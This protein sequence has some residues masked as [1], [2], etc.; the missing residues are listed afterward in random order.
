MNMPRP[1]SS[2]DWR[3]RLVQDLEPL[4]KSD[5]LTAE[6][7]RHQGVPFAL[8]AYPPTDERVL[9]R[10]L[11]LLRT[12]VE[13]ETVRKVTVFSMAD[14]VMDAIRAVYGD[15]GLA[16]LAEMERSYAHLKTKERLDLLRG[17][18]ES[19][20]S[21]HYPVPAV[22]KKQMTTLDP[23]ASV[24]FITRIGRLYPFFRASALLE[25][26]MYEVQVPTILF[27]PGTRGAGR[28]TLRFMD[29]LEAVHSYRHRIF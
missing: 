8:F 1:W 14:L 3:R 4:L 11:S 2:S 9:R 12:R 6:I 10:E 21:E 5:D 13:N 28:N 25:N 16:H 26:L 22:L 20:L 23:Q 27:Y 17:Q 19:I 15:G 24:V 7:S 29:S 18:I